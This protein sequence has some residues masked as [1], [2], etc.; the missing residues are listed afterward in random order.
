MAV[1]GVDGPRQVLPRHVEYAR[2]GPAGDVG[3]RDR[4]RHDGGA[5]RRGQRA[6]AATAAARDVAEA[7]THDVAEP[8]TKEEV[9]EEVDGGVEDL[10]RVGNEHDVEARRAARAKAVAED[11]L[12]HLAGRLARHE[13]DDDDDHH[14]RDVVVVGGLAADEAAAA[15]AR[16]AVRQHDA[17]VDDGEEEEWREEGKDVVEDVGVDDGVEAALAERRPLPRHVVARP[18]VDGDLEETRDVVENGG[19]GDGGDLATDEAG[20]AEGGRSI[21]QADGDAAVGGD[22][23]RQPDGER[24]RHVEEREGV[25]AHREEDDA[26][27][28]GVGRRGGGREAADGVQRV[29]CEPE[30]EEEA[31]GDRERAEEERRD[32]GRLVA[33]Q[34]EERDG[35]A[36]EAGDAK[37]DADDA[38]EQEAEQ[39]ARGGEA[40][41]RRRGVRRDGKVGDAVAEGQR[42][43]R[44]RR[45]DARHVEERARCVHR[46]VVEVASSRSLPGAAIYR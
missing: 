39:V 41:R 26:G 45:R 29:V 8:A 28:G 31:V 23:D 46:D 19:D 13:D 21:R 14:Q 24:L 30:G 25:D 33:T 5:G 38:V 27:E 43:R 1:G 18:P 42:C 35:V 17:R 12:R 9:D 32:A 15:G 6:A 22:D 11:D 2:A 40:R 3:E 16:H 20:H 37:R 10:E 36:D 44:R 7:R 4:L 34:R